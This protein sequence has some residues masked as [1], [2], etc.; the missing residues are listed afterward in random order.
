MGNR[1]RFGAAGFSQQVRYYSVRTVGPDRQFDTLDDLTV[2]LEAHPGT[3]PGHEFRIARLRV[4]RSWRERDG[5]TRK[6]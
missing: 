1:L 3:G 2:V 4:L 6:I 5:A